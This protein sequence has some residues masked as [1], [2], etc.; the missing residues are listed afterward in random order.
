R[1]VIELPPRSPIVMADRDRLM[2]V[3]LNLLSN[4]IKFVPP[5]TGMVRLRVSA[6]ASEVRVEVEDN[7]TGIASGEEELVFEKF[8]QGGNTL[9]DK[10]KGTGL[11]L[12][13]SREIV[14]A[15]GGRLWVETR[16]QEDSLGGAHFVCS[17]PASSAGE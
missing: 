11:G 17:L 4:A 5:G 15:F 2:Q 14:Q 6:S 10:P 9:T 7:G 12:P 13:I 3:V 1:I 8:R 16:K